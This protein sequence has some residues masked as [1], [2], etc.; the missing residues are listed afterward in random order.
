MSALVIAALAVAALVLAGALALWHFLAAVF[1][2]GAPYVW[3]S[4][5]ERRQAPLRQASRGGAASVVTMLRSERIMLLAQDELVFRLLGDS[6]TVYIVV[7][8]THPTCACAAF[9][10]R[11]ARGSQT[12]VCKHLAFVLVK[13]LSMPANHYLLHQTAWLSWELAY[14]L[15]RPR[16][17]VT[18]SRPVLEA[19]GLVPPRVLDYDGVCPVCRDPFEDGEATSRCAACRVL[20]HSSCVAAYNSSQLPAQPLCAACRAPW[21]ADVLRVES[22][23]VRGV[24]RQRLTA[25]VAVKRRSGSAMA[26]G[27]KAQVSATKKSNK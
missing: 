10:Y 22:V 2:C 18:A 16:G 4:A 21:S 26:G 20:F 1:P 19:F 9:S 15:A 3:V 11:F 5:W 8:G 27:R 24:E 23:V 17:G 25:G 7:L 14:W 12:A 6:G 13:V